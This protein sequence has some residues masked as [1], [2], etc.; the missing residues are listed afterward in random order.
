M[1]QSLGP[2][3]D[4]DLLHRVATVAAFLLAGLGAISPIL[5]VAAFEFRSDWFADPA[6]AVA[7]GSGGAP[8]LQWAALTD[9]F[10]YYLPLA[11]IALVIR[12][13]IRPR[14]PVLVDAATIA[15]LGY[16]I[17]GSIGVTALASAGPAMMRAYDAPG[18][19]QAAVPVAFRLLIE[20]VFRGVWQT[21]DP[22]LLGFWFLVVGGL[23]RP[24]RPA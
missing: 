22:I 1:T 21:L 2:V 11:P 6:L 15:A 8:I 18:A 7:G 10:S 17:A 9:L 4:E 13:T 16:V 24:Q 20:I 23:T 12:V 5:I 14:S 3:A 19:D